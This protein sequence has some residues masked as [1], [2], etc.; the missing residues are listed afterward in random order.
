MD[1][2]FEFY[3]IAPSFFIDQADLKKRYYR[4]SRSLHPDFY[5]QASTEEQDEAL[6][7]SA[8]NN[9]AYNTLRNEDALLEYILRLEEVLVEGQTPAL[10]Q[11]FLME[12]MD[13]NEAV[14]D[15]QMS[16]DAAGA[17]SVLKQIASIESDIYTEA[18][19]EMEAYNAANEEQKL[20]KVLQFYL[21]KKYLLRIKDNLNTFTRP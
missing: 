12:M 6:R 1:N 16:E 17:E 13:I 8:V 11:M 19:A 9:T 2:Y 3:E 7:L 20:E 21:K 10:D 4:K 15:V 5:T 14:M 18:E